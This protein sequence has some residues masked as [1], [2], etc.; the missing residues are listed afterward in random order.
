[1]QPGA[2][3]GFHRRPAPL[4]NLDDLIEHALRHFPLRSLWHFG[5]LI[6][7]DDGDFIAIGVETDAFAGYVVDHN[8]VK[9]LSYELLTGVFEHVLGLRGEANDN[10]RLLARGDFFE[11][12]SGRFQF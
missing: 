2:S 7:R 8:G 4:A 11:N 6:V 5:D 3:S 9:V 12:V 10:L 1:M